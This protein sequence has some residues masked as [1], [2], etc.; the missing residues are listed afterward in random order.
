MHVHNRRSE[1]QAE[2]GTRPRARAF[3]PHEAFEGAAAIL[4]GNAGA[5]VGDFD[6]NRR[7]LA[8]CDDG[9]LRPGRG[10]VR[11]RAV[12]D[13]VVDQI[14]DRLAD[15]LAVAH[16]RQALR[17]FDLQR[18]AVLLGDRG[19][20]LGD[21]LDRLAEV[22]RAHAGAARPP[23]SARAIISNAL[24]TRIRPSD[25]SIVRSSAAR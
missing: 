3:E 12:L 10:P 16:H 11:R 7:A 13:R 24:K 1:R 20:E 8:P 6:R 22:E 15:Q 14:G 2:A 18:R 9:D 4:G 19:V 5:V 21:A 23:A 25:S 17:R